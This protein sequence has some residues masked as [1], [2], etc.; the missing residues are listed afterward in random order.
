M[1]SPRVPTLWPL[2]LLGATGCARGEAQE[3]IGTILF[4]V[5]G[6]MMIYVV[7][8]GAL[9]LCGLG[10]L[11]VELLVVVLNLV[12]P[13]TT[14]MVAGYVL[15]V[16]H[17]LALIS[18][19]AIFIWALV[20]PPPEPLES[21]PDAVVLPAENG[22]LGPALGFGTNLFFGGALLGSAV[23]A[24]RKLDAISQR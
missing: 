11:M 19:V 10:I 9:A 2:L 12:R 14:S 20:Q 23:H 16:M 22:L 1:R 24:R 3:V 21:L 5:M 6:A 17:V 18:G 7:V 4:A 15:G 13:S 8:V